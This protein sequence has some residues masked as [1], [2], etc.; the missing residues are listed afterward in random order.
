MSGDKIKFNYPKRVSSTR[1]WL[2]TQVAKSLGKE[3][4]QDESHEFLFEFLDATR[5]VYRELVGEDE[6]IDW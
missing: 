5:E 2:L 1:Q 4:A 3:L 6:I